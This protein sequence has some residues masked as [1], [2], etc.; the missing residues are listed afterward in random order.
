MKNDAGYASSYKDMKPGLFKKKP[1][2]K[3]GLK[4]EEA[5][6]VHNYTDLGYQKLNKQLRNPPPDSRIKAKQ[7]L[8]DSALS[9]LPDHKGEVFRG[10]DKKMNFEVGAVVKDGGFSSSSPNKDIATINFSGG[11]L[12]KIKSKTGKNITDMSRFRS[13]SE[14]LFKSGTGFKV[15]G[16]SEDKSG[17]IVYE[18]EE[19]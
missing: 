16:K 12:F 2:Q 15:T 19:I 3:A 8:L 17:R 11:T 14:V 1:W 13:E 9:K 18:M 7:A 4:R 5:A 6:T 10:V